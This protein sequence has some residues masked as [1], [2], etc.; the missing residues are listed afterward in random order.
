[1]LL[2]QRQIVEWIT[3]VPL[4]NGETRVVEIGN[5]A[6]GEPILNDAGYIF[7]TW[8]YKSSHASTI[9]IQGAHEPTFAAADVIYTDPVGGVALATPYDLVAPIG[10]S[11]YVPLLKPFIRIRLVNTAGV[12]HTYTRFYAKA[13]G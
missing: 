11:G 6:S 2:R 8:S 4:V 3:D 10:D 13:W 5:V 7:I 9:E 1:M 12:D